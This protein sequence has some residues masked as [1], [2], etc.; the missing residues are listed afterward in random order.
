MVDLRVIGE[1]TVDA[2]LFWHLAI[3]FLRMPPF[4]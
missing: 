4:G 1:L 3:V 2:A